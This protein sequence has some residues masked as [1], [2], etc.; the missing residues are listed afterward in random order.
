MTARACELRV[1]EIAAGAQTPAARRALACASR[2]SPSSS[3]ASALRSTCRARARSAS[4]RTRRSSAAAGRAGRCRSCCRARAPSRPLR[5]SLPWPAQDAPE[6]LLARAEVRAPAVVLEAREHAR[7]GR[8]SS[9]SETSIATLPIRRGPSSRTVCTSSSPTPCD[10]LLAERVGVPEQLVAAAHAEHDRAA[11]R[12]RVQRRRAW[13]RAG[14]RRTGAGRGPGRRRGRRGRARRA[15]SGSPSPLA[16]SS[17]PIPRH[18]QR[19]SSTSRLPRS[20]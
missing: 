18:A 12:R 6:R 5:P 8:R 4:R 20:A 17:K 16:S 14:P 15:S 7:A 10:L 2:S 3:G 9:S 11:R 1:C 13:S 19:R